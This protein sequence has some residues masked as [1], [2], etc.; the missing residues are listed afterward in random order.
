MS[1]SSKTKRN[2]KSKK[3]T[4]LHELHAAPAYK[5]KPKTDNQATLL[6]VMDTYPMVLALGSAG[7][8]KT[9]CVAYKAAR[10][11][12][13]SKIKNIVLTRANQP[14]GKS[15][16]SF[17]GTIAEKMT[18]WLMPILTNLKT[19]LGSGK[20]ECAMKS[21]IE[22]QPIETVRG[23]SFDDSFIIVDEAQNLTFEEVKAL[24]TRIGENSIMVFCGDPSQHDLKTKDV[25][26]VKFA[27][28]CSKHNIDLP[29]IN[30]T[31]DDIV[32]SDIVGALCR[33]FEKEKV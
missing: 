26:I 31:V 13:D 6:H 33:M 11:L 29:T 21:S 1:K 3:E 19:A 20:F 25:A 12:L 17:P 32:R 5:I 10:L 23:R 16:G 8:G 4:F 9:Y 22:I 30:F 24:S 7:T 15:L 14:T 27:E 18:P 2:N 28:M